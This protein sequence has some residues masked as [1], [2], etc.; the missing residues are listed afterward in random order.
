[1]TDETKDEDLLSLQALARAG[2]LL[3]EREAAFARISSPWL[4][5]AAAYRVHD[6]QQAI[7]DL[8]HAGDHASEDTI[9]PVE[10]LLI[11]EANQELAPATVGDRVAARSSR[12][13][14]TA[15]T[16]STTT[17]TARPTTSTPSAEDRASTPAAGSPTRAQASTPGWTRAGTAP[18]AGAAWAGPL[19]GATGW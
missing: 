2:V 6:N 19:P 11:I 1:M 4:K 15:R 10:L 7:D 17:A 16:P 13:P 9:G 5:L 12:R 3:G 18:A 14:K 8:V